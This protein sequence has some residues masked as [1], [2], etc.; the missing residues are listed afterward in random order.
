[1]TWKTF[2]RTRVHTSRVPD[3]KE[4]NLV[5]CERNVC[6]RVPSTAATQ[7]RERSLQQNDSRVTFITTWAHFVSSNKHWNN[8]SQKITERYCLFSCWV[9]VDVLFI[10]KPICFCFISFLCLTDDRKHALVVLILFVGRHEEVFRRKWNT[11]VRFVYCCSSEGYAAEG[12]NLKL[13]G[14]FV[15]LHTWDAAPA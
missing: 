4:T 2:C 1:M 12:T 7:A 14:S 13:P 5:V 6:D 15:Y 9:F 10:I 11:H 8:P 3:K